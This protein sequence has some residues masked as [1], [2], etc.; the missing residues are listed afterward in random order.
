MVTQAISVVAQLSLPAETLS[1]LLI[2]AGLGLSI[3]EAF[4]P[5][6]HFVVLGVSLLATGLV[7]LLLGTASPLVLS[8]LVVLFGAAALLGYREFDI[9]GTTGSEQTSDSNS[10]TGTY[11]RVT[12]RVTPTQGQVKLD[13][14][15][16]DPYYSARSVDDELTAGTEVVVVDPGGGNVL[17][18]E[19]LVGGVDEIDRA[20]ATEQANRETTNSENEDPTPTPTPNSNVTQTDD[21]QSDEQRDSESESGL[22]SESEREREREPDLS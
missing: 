18:V 4:A 13:A 14:G 1:L 15:G 22:E 10:L 5:G 16:F 11:G 3:L 6:A 9:Y 19:P 21:T 8:G 20:L 2:T 12:E 7:G 17:T